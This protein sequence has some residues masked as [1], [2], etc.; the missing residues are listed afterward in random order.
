MYNL[1]F[2]D[3]PWISVPN[4]LEEDNDVRYAELQR[5]ILNDYFVSKAREV[6]WQHDFVQREVYADN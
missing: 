5:G 3:S 1:I 2:Q 6:E 4:V